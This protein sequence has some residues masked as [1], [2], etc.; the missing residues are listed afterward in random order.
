LIN[1]YSLAKDWLLDTYTGAAGAYAVRRLSGSYA[2]ACLR[3]RRSNDNTEQ[4]IGFDAGG[5]LDEAQLTAFVGANSGFVTT[6]YDQS[7]NGRNITQTTSGNQPRIVNSG[8]VDKEGGRPT[9][10]FDGSN[11]SF[12]GSTAVDPLFITV[13]NTINTTAAFKT[14]LGADATDVSPTVRV[15]SFYFQYSTPTRSP[16]FGRTTTVDTTVATDFIAT[17]SQISNNTRVLMTGTRSTTA[18]EVFINSASAGTDT[19]SSALRSVGG[20]DSGKPR[21][22]AG[23]YSD[24][25]V[26]FF[27]GNIQEIVL[28]TSDQTA[29]RSAIETAINGYYS[30]Y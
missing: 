13:V 5:N 9:L 19:T 20:V 6:W 22:G 25:V 11:D 17:G 10:I 14:I 1:P 26:D 2:G 28:Y 12:L 4:D 18:I 21:I 3:V 16:A 7:G 23:Y 27:P 15:G 29:N 24:T 8:T 30:I